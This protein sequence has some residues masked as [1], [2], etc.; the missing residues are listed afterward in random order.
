LPAARRILP[1]ATLAARDTPPRATLAA[2]HVLPR[3]ML[4]ARDTPP[5]ATLAA[6]HVLPRV[7]RRVRH[8]GRVVAAAFVRLG[9]TRRG[10]V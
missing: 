5:R 10:G 9:R 2:R 1:R 4:A 3:A 6:R 8:L 7:T